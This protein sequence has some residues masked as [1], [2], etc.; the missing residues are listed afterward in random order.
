MIFVK[1]WRGKDRWCRDK[2]AMHACTAAGGSLMGSLACCRRVIGGYEILDFAI[3]K[4][5]ISQ[6]KSY[7]S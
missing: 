5:A 2:E 3:P 6:A 4:T 7:R 1:R